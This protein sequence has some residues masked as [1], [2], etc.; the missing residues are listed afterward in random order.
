MM[1]N[2]MKKTI[3]SLKHKKTWK[4]T[5]QAIGTAPDIFFNLTKK[6][7]GTFL[8]SPKAFIGD[9]MFLKKSLDS[10]SETLRE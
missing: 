4:A 2:K 3:L 10:R 9:P 1:A 7:A 5:R 6:P 8:S